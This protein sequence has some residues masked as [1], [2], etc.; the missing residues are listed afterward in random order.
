MHKKCTS[1]GI[2]KVY[3]NKPSRCQVNSQMVYNSDVRLINKERPGIEDFMGG[4]K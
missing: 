1:K 3:R 2:N 4:D